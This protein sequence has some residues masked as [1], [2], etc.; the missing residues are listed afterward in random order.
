[1]VDWHVD[2]M[3]IDVLGLAKKLLKD[4]SEMGSH[5]TIKMLDWTD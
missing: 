5:I 2:R 4:H 1:M 3:S